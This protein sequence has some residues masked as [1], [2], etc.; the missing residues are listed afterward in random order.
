M[1]NVAKIRK[2]VPLIEGAV[3]V[4]VNAGSRGKGVRNDVVI[5]GSELNEF[6]VSRVVE[7]ID[8]GFCVDDALL[9]LKDGFELEF[10]DV[11]E[12]TH[13]KNLKDVRS[14]IIGRDGRARKTIEKLSG[15]E[16]VLSGNR[17]GVIV[18]SEHMSAVAQG[19]QSL[20]S[21]A[22]H[23]NVFGMLER[24]GVRAREGLDGDLGLRSS[25]KG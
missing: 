1:Q 9:L 21:G 22:K 10:I 15:A 6:L 5:K 11:K 17:V 19:I 14:R 3:R 25:E 8:F 18:D 24:A 23:G 2:A 20:I 4:R 12:H 16:I 13:R 7:A